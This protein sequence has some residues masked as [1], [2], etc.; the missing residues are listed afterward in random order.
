LQEFLP[1]A[2]PTEESPFSQHGDCRS[3]RLPSHTDSFETGLVLH[4][5][6]STLHGM[7]A[8]TLDQ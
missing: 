3:P 8:C 6:G 2:V 1:V 5:T 4:Y 7:I